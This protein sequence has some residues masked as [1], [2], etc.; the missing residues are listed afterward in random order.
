V[1]K[2]LVAGLVSRVVVYIQRRGKDDR[3]CWAWLCYEDRRWRPVFISE[4]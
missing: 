1:I 4:D 3:H 2:A